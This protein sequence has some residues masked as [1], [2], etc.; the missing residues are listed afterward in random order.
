VNLRLLRADHSRKADSEMADSSVEHD[1]A[2]CF[3]GFHCGEVGL[4]LVQAGRFC[5]VAARQLGKIFL[6]FFILKFL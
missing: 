5:R 6:N 1:G 3:T 2:S 4:M